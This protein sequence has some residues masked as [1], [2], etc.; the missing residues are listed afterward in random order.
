MARFAYNNDVPEYKISRVQLGRGVIFGI[1]RFLQVYG[2]AGAVD[3]L[4][5]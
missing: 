1:K 5:H 3:Y 4:S 2:A